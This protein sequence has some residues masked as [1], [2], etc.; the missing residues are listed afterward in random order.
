MLPS[1]LKRPSAQNNSVD[2]QTATLIAEL[3][4]ASSHLHKTHWKITGPGSYAAHIA[5]NDF[6][7]AIKAHA[8]SLA[9]GYQGAEQKLLDIPL[10]KEE[11]ACD[12]VDDALSYLRE[13][14]VKINNLQ[15]VMPHSEIVNE[16]DEAKSS[17]NT[18]LYKL[19]FLQ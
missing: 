6:Y 11:Y 18:A 7:D 16:L 17:I 1:S 14:K 3:L 4:N 10:V 19:T 9:E 8:D 12:S 2:A 13:L 15:G 5:L